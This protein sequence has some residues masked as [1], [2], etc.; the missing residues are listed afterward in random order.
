MQ[1][2]VRVIFGVVVF[3]PLFAFAQAN[4]QSEIEA[5]LRQIAGLQE[6][7]TN[8]TSGGGGRPAGPPPGGGGGGPGAM[9]RIS[10]VQQL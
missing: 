6:Q 10:R 3:V 4:T 1:T 8:A 9:D 2:Y 5:L 7:L